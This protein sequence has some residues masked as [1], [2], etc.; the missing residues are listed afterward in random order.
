LRNG[1]HE[2]FCI[3]ADLA[4]VQAPATLISEVLSSFKTTDINILVNNAGLGDNRPLGEVTHESYNTL[5]DIN[6]RAGVF[7]T[8][9]VLPYITRGGRIT[10]L[11]STSA[12]GGYPT[13]SIYAAS[14]AAIEG[15]ARV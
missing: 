7:T 5:M 10:N 1:G 9:A 2:A 14:K 6:V 13:Q 3:Q 11:S 12:R 8:Q 15:L 4:N